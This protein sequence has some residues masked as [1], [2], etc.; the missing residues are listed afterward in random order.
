MILYDHDCFYAFLVYK[1]NDLGYKTKR[2]IAM[3][4]RDMITEIF[5][6]FAGGDPG[7]YSKLVIKMV[8][9]FRP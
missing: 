8:N 2:R 5:N 1:K 3:E 9:F 6:H 4:L 7:R